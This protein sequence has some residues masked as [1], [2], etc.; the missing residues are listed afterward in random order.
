[1]ALID[2]AID[3]AT[4]VLQK[5]CDSFVIS[6]YQDTRVFKTLED[7]VKNM[8]PKDRPRAVIVGSP[9]MF[10]G[11][12]S[13]GRDIEMQILKYFPGVA[14][15]IEK[16]IATGPAHEINEAFTIAKT[17]SDSKTV[18]SVGRVLHFKY[19]LDLGVYLITDTCSDT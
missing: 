9:P 12:L 2:P 3:R 10:R 11:A 19:V 1:V 15:F 17:I 14:M 16:P 5:K 4:A 6:A 8:S 13:Q 18:C 7:F